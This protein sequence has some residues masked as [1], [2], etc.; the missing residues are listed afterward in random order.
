MDNDK[1]GSENA[2]QDEA[3]EDRGLEHLC[4]MLA[5]KRSQ[6]NIYSIGAV[7]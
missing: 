2:G 3:V 1:E 5:G 7:L 4:A 6:K